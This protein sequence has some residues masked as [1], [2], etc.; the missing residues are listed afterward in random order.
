MTTNSKVQLPAI[1]RAE[2][3]VSMQTTRIPRTFTPVNSPEEKK[4]EAKLQKECLR[5][6]KLK[7]HSEFRLNL[8]KPT[9]QTMG[10]YRNNNCKKCETPSTFESKEDPNLKIANL[11]HELEEFK[12]QAY[13]TIDNFK[14][15]IENLISHLKLKVN[16][17]FTVSPS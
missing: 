12:T 2:D 14:N 10:V 3:W 16:D 6:K 15:V 8:S 11:E 4:D 9:D 17:D 5:C 7:Y 13:Q 1:S